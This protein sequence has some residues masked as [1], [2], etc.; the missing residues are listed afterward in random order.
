M[1]QAIR[2]CQRI[3][4]LFVLVA[5]VLSTFRTDQSRFKFVPNSLW[6]I[7]TDNILHKNE[8]LTCVNDLTRL[9]TL[10][11]RAAVTH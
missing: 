10:M 1:S 5:T 8:M 2:T 9:K 7:S 4:C 11:S 3:I 6:A